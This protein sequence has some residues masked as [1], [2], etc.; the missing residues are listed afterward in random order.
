MS[1]EENIHKKWMRRAI[2][3]AALGKGLTSPNPMVGAV[4]INKSG[5]L[6]AEGFHERQVR[7]MQKQWL[8]VI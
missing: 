4:I 2:Q 1:F 3:L 7:N 6:I 5:K 8:L